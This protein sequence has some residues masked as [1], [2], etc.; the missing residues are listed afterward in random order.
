M[1]VGLRLTFPENSLGDY[2]KVCETLNFPADWPV[3]LLAHS[4]YEADGHL[5]VADVWE[6]R[7]AF[8]SFVQ[9]RLQAAMGQALG[10]RAREPEIL[11]RDLHTFN[12]H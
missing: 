6:S 4:S 2:D 1:P 9:Q 11:E 5:M 8:D 10:D 7:Q 3:G 12:T